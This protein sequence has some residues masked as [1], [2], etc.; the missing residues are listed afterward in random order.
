[1]SVHE[2]YA[3]DLALY[4]LGCLE[5]DETGSLDKHLEGCASCRRELEQLRGDA[6]LLALTAS[7]PRPPARA[8]TRLLDAIAEKPRTEGALPW[9]QWWAALGWLAAAVMIVAVTTVWRQ[10]VRLKSS[11]VQSAG[12]LERQRLELEQ[13]RRI[14]DLLKASD[15]VSYEVLPVSLKTP[16]PPAG[17]AIYSRQQNGLVFVA[18][19]LRALPSDK[20]YELWLIPNQGA[21]I[22]AGVFKPDAHGGAVVINPPLPAGVEAKAFAITIEAEQGSKTPTHPIIMMGAGG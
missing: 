16:P 18:S 10:N 17:K 11:V 5:S 7:G 2:Q 21:P 20:A 13:A 8:R 15:A 12:M 4:A 14:A 3:E 19:N 9:T 1:M 6:A 22:P